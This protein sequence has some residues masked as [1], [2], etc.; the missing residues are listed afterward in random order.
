M[1]CNRSSSVARLVGACSSPALSLS[2][3]CLFFC[4]FRVLLHA[5]RGCGAT[6]LSS[7]HVSPKKVSLVY[8]MP[9]LTDNDG[10]Q[11][12]HADSGQRDRLQPRGAPHS[13]GDFARENGHE[14]VAR[15]SCR[16]C[17]G[18]CVAVQEPG[19][20]ATQSSTVEVFTKHRYIGPLLHSYAT[21]PNVCTSR[22]TRLLSPIP[23]TL[24]RFETIG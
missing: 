2:S 4:C 5:E 13:K 10:R 12:A 11:Q 24:R 20:S 3:R 6:R 21:L 1:S 18:L 9:R 16:R 19:K 15:C 22:G 7:Y 17:G 8:C 23:E 14:R